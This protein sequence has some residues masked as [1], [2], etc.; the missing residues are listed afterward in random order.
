M[1][2]GRDRRDALLRARFALG[3][4]PLTSFRGLPAPP[5]GWTWSNSVLGGFG[6][7]G[8]GGCTILYF[9]GDLVG[10][11]RAAPP[12]TYPAHRGPGGQARSVT[13]A[14]IVAG[15]LLSLQRFRN[16]LRMFVLVP[17]QRALK[18]R[19]TDGPVPLGRAAWAPDGVRS[20]PVPAPTPPACP[21]GGRR[22]GPARGAQGRGPHGERSTP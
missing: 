10:P 17:R 19:A 9:G 14:G 4:A 8:G 6:P 5:A 1:H 3:L 16:L 13:R 15:D 22:A 7:P 18:R 12:H 11:R 21:T 2:R 20:C